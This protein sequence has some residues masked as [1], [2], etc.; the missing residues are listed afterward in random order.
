MDKTCCTWVLVSKLYVCYISVAGP[1]G[2]FWKRVLLFCNKWICLRNNSAWKGD[3]WILSAFSVA[4]S[5]SIFCCCCWSS[6]WVHHCFDVKIHGE[7]SLTDLT[8]FGSVYILASSPM[9]W[10]CN[11]HFKICWCGF[12]WLMSL[13]PRCLSVLFRTAPCTMA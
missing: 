6:L 9:T 8:D 2:S 5:W 1:G 13:F 4:K 11:L 7:V 10:A 3:L 12:F